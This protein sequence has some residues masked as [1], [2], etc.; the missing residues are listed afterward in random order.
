[1][2]NPDKFNSWCLIE[3][4]GRQRIVGLVTEQAIGGASFIRVDVPSPDGTVA[5]TRIYGAAAIYAISP[6]DRQTAIALAQQCDAAP[7]KSYELPEPKRLEAGPDSGASEP[8]DED[9]ERNERESTYYG[10]DA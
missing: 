6:I 7:V 4:F 9:E 3:L 2:S 5:F 1:M 10:G 8:E